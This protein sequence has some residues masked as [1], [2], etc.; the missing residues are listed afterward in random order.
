MVKGLT[1]NW[2][3]QTAEIFEQFW[4][5][6]CIIIYPLCDFLQQQFSVGVN[7]VTR[8]LERMEPCTKLGNPSVSSNTKASSVKL[9]VGHP[10]FSI[11]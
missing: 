4:E 7:D 11:M 3:M 1:S 6:T 2:P 8:M 5:E 10:C 9:Q